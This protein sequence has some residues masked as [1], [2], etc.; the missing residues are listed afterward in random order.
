MLRLMETDG[1]VKPR[2]ILIVLALVG[3]FIPQGGGLPVVQPFSRKIRVSPICIPFVLNVLICTYL[4]LKHLL[5]V[6]LYLYVRTVCYTIHQLF[7]GIFFFPYALPE[8]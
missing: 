2:E 1:S 3:P 4:N 7:C 8:H 5:L 6:L